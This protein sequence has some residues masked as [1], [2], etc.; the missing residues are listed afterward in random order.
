MDNKENQ[1]WRLVVLQ[2]AQ[3]AVRALKGLPAGARDQDAIMGRS[4]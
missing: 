2:Q 3:A 1:R 4:F